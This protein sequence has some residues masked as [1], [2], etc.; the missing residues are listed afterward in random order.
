MPPER[1]EAGSG[2]P[3]GSDDADTDAA[4]TAAM[5]ARQSKNLMKGTML[6]WT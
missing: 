1:S 5:V 2:D 4:V 3:A 6:I